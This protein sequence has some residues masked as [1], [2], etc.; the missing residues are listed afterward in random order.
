MNRPRTAACLV[1]VA[2]MCTLHSH[3]MAEAP[4][5]AAQL[6]KSCLAWIDEPDSV[7]AMA[8][9]GY[10]TGFLDGAF[11]LDA[12]TRPHVEVARETLLDRARRTRLGPRH[13]H[14]APYCVSA[15]VPIEQIIHQLLSHYET[16]RFRDD[17]DAHAVV[18]ST[19][20]RFH[21]C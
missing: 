3:V 10:V 1:S 5:S 9:V 17:L 15:A 8:C 11:F 13:T 7:A 21:P 2:L 6:R 20:R 19:L 18:A 14:R 4:L 12:R 16:R